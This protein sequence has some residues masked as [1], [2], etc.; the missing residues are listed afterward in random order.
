MLFE[1]T[2]CTE[3]G[4]FL[5]RSAILNSP[6]PH[7]H[8]KRQNVMTHFPAVFFAEYVVRTVAS[9]VFL[10]EAFSRTDF[11]LSLPRKKGETIFRGGFI[12]K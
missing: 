10:T 5:K 9:L 12:F 6:H 3:P 7:S 8:N 11:S 4:S 1:F 2:P